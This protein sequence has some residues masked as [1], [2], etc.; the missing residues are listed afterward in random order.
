MSAADQTGVQ[1]TAH[2]TQQQEDIIKQFVR[3][4]LT[5]SIGNL[6]TE[7]ISHITTGLGVATK[8]IQDDIATKLDE[9]KNFMIKLESQQEALRVL[10]S[11]AGVKCLTMEEFVSAEHAKIASTMSE[12]DR[13]KKEM[14]DMD[15][16]NANR[17]TQAR[18]D[19]ESSSSALQEQMRR[20]FEMSESQL[21]Q[22]S[23]SIRGEIDMIK[24]VMEATA[25]AK[26]FTPDKPKGL[27]DTRDF[28]VS[29]MPE[30]CTTEQ[31]KQWRH[32]VL[33]FLEAH[34]KWAGAKRVLNQVRKSVS[35]IGPAAL[36][37]A[38]DSANAESMQEIREFVVP[39][40][41]KWSF[42][43]RTRELYQLISV[44]LNTA[45]FG[46]FKDEDMMNGFELWRLLNKAKDPV[47]KDIAFH[48]E[49]QIQQMAF[50]KERTFDATYA[51][52]LE[53]DKAAKNYK[54]Q[55]GE[56]VDQHLLAR[57]LYAVAEDDTTDKIDK[58]DSGVPDK[59]ASEFYEKFREWLGEKWEKQ[60]G[61]TM[62][63]KH[64]RSGGNN[65][66]VGAVSEESKVQ[67]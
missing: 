37:D 65:M 27:I 49:L 3:E 26:G 15:L 46:D 8:T 16:D 53:I 60:A 19:L 62:V 57:V 30:N 13:I 44:K 50:T 29:V 40:K 10:Q 67:E 31:Y 66:D 56:K 48:L 45:T 21:Q 42:A 20:V 47:R 24:N 6:R 38:I 33:I 54:A 59:D 11:E 41:S 14:G 18:I 4:N 17:N 2:F 63:R 34:P 39:D 61:R 25:S 22:V 9:A 36:S 12:L 55:T 5:I 58:D 43:E 52:M 32:H 23:T 28:K 64:Q 1:S 51:R 35:V 7:M